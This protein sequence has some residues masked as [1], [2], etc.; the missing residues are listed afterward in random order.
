M[1]LNLNHSLPYLH[2]KTFLCPKYS[3]TDAIHSQDYWFSFVPASQTDHAHLNSQQKKKAGE[4]SMAS[5]G[6]LGLCFFPTLTTDQCYRVTRGS[7][8]S[9]LYTQH[10]AYFVTRGRWRSKIIRIKLIK[11]NHDFRAAFNLIA[12]LVVRKHRMIWNFFS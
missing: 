5:L 11:W 8:L 2:W 10:G 9:K 6:V 4:G 3:S 1:Q 7:F 12:R